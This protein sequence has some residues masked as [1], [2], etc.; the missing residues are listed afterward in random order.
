M[1]ERLTRADRRLIAGALAVLAISLAIGFHLFPR[2]FPEASIRFSVDRGESGRRG[3]ALLRDLGCDPARHVHA[4]RFAY[5][6]ETKVFLEREMGLGRADSA[7]SGE[8]RLWRWAHRWFRPGEEEEY[9]VAY[10]TTGELASFEHRVPEAAPA[11]SL[12]ADSARA[13]AESFL[14]ARA[15][16]DTA[17]LALVGTRTTARPHRLDH[18]FTWEVRER[19]WAGAPLRIEVTVQGARVGALR[20]YLDVPEA[21][22]RAYA[23]LRSR[24]ETTGLVASIAYALL[25]LWVAVTFV[26]RAPRRALRWRTAS[27]FALAAL[28]LV[29][30]AQLNGMTAGLFDFDTH[31]TLSAFLTLRML[32]LIGQCVGTAFFVFLLT[33]GAES[34]YREAL[35]AKMSL[36]GL[37]TRR[38]LRTR[39]F[40]LASIVGFALTGFFFAYQAVFYRLA[41]ALGAWAPAEIPYDELLNTSLPWAVVLL[42]GFSPAVTEEFSARMFGVPALG[43]LFRSRAAGVAV[44]AAIWGFSH[45]SYPNQPFYIRGVEVGLAGVV[46]G[47]VMLRFGI[48]ATLVWHYTVDAFYTAYLLLRSGNPYFVASGA[49]AA[50]ALLVPF[51][52]ALAMYLRTRRFDDGAGLR[53][54]DFAAPPAPPPAPREEVPA[55]AYAPL[56][57]R[58]WAVVCLVAGIAVVAAYLAPARGWGSLGR[59]SLPRSRAERIGRAELRA[60]GAPVESLRTAVWAETRVGPEVYRYGAEQAGVARTRD[61]LSPY[62]WVV[63]AFAPGREEEWSVVLGAER[64]ERIGFEH[65]VAEAA[66]GDTLSG[67]EARAKGDSSLAAQGEVLSGWTLRESREVP[68]PARR[69]WLFTWEAGDSA[70]RIGEGAVREEVGL[71]GGRIGSERRFF[72]LPEDWWRARE[73][74]GPFAAVRAA[75][76]GLLLLGGLWYAARRL[77]RENRA[78]PIRWRMGFAAAAVVAA[79]QLAALA[80]GWRAELAGYDTSQPWSLFLLQSALMRPFAALLLAFLLGAALSLL[81]GLHPRIGPAL[82]ARNRGRY[83]RDA[84][85]GALVV[86]AALA[87]LARLRVLLESWLPG[88]FPTARLALPPGIDHAWA[89]PAALGASLTTAGIVAIVGGLGVFVVARNGR[90]TPIGLALV[91]VATLALVP[92]SARGAGEVLAAWLSL[93]A[94]AAIALALARFVLRDNVPGYVLACVVAG[95]AGPVTLLAAHPATRGSAAALVGATLATMLVFSL[96]RRGASGGDDL[97]RVFTDPHVGASAGVGESSK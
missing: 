92:A 2:V 86:L 40:F 30:L 61:L 78:T 63:R 35:P 32:A 72:H 66:R 70:R 3:A 90:L 88:A 89:L 12:A 56:A 75:A 93:V 83:A 59:V 50:G 28:A 77:S 74:R 68:R 65:T 26:R 38:G 64:G 1:P 48:L 34:V 14:R 57:P 58:R 79:A 17:R 69:D 76:L 31:Q 81:T 20:T 5:D 51:A 54:A 46:T 9:R 43:K 85:L 4:A 27:G 7:F 52:Y 84:W 8:I 41:D 47:L 44:A 29:F 96:P 91:L 15:G 49:L 67:E 25:L 87:V 10:A 19:R 95:A 33:A 23:A 53:N 16:Y 82:H 94:T 80:L 13:I 21:W 45:A 22:S 37:F 62:A 11:E 42:V 97:K 71:L 36:G 39:E 55:L 73:T 6:E 24:N 18:A 60:L